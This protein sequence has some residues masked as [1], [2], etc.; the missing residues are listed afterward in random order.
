MHAISRESK[1][2]VIWQSFFKRI[3]CAPLQKTTDLANSAS[4]KIVRTRHARIT[5][6]VCAQSTAHQMLQQ[7]FQLVQDGFLFTQKSRCRGRMCCAL[8]LS[9]SLEPC[10][11]LPDPPAEASYSRMKKASTWRKLHLLYH[12]YIRRIILITRN[13]TIGTI[14]VA[15]CIFS[16]WGY[17]SG[18]RSRDN[19]SIQNGNYRSKRSACQ[20]RL[21]HLEPHASNVRHGA[22]A[23]C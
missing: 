22:V 15:N 3:S 13:F 5:A 2:L 14:H 12:K 21:A 8:T 18:T 1:S 10:L 16:P 23:P 19:Q 11:A 6:G 7:S 9:C 17:I 20:T 4:Y